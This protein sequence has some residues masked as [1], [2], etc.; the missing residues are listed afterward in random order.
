MTAPTIWIISPLIVSL[1]L[2]FIRR[3][4]R[5][6]NIIALSYCVLL[7]WMAWQLPIGEPMSMGPWTLKIKEQ[8]LVYGRQFTIQSVDKPVLVLIYL[9]A[10]A[11]FAG[12]LLAQPGY[13]FIPLGLGIV[14]LLIAALSI[15]P[16]LYAALLI[17]M[18][19]L[20]SVPL[21]N[22]PG[23]LARKGVIRL[24]TIQTIGMPLI[25][26]TGWMLTGVETSPSD[27]DLV[28]RA[29]VFLAFGFLL[30]LGVFPFH[31]WIPMLMSEIHPYTGAFFIST[32]MSVLSIFGLGFLDRFVWLRDSAPV[33]SI[34][35]LSGALM[36]VVGGIS[37]ALERQLGRI[38]GFAFVSDIGLTLIAL[39]IES[40]AGV[41]AFF[42]IIIL[43][44]VN[45]LVWALA[46]SGFY[47]SDQALDYDNFRLDAPK[48]PIVAGVIIIASFSV[49]GFP[50]LSGFPIRLL[51][52]REFAV[53]H[54]MVS[55]G[56][57]IGFVGLTASGLRTLFHLLKSYDRAYRI[58]T[59]ER[60]VVVIF[61]SFIFI[62][63]LLGLIPNI[64]FEMVIPFLGMYPRLIP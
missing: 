16:F 22:P 4:T 14:A 3:Q 44:M 55:S 32:L 21:L 11:W 41:E 18:A 25:L 33:Y 13:L 59:D 31:T 29:T 51:L 47:K 10:T 46:L 48:Y 15:E 60:V 62:L 38:L 53:N 43:R 23:S 20:L 45:S 34:L 24:L 49:A 30:L 1:F 35:N 27:I 63:I 28:V 61:G 42:A 12:S 52:W 2:F 58:S 19:V 64:I 56:L 17:E 6:V 36:L 57:L 9:S 37:A 5:L 8:L 50:L 7:V 40:Q 54:L 39:G 26:I